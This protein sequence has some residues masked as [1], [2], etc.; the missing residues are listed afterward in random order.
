MTEDNSGDNLHK[1]LFVNLIVMLSSS[2]MQQLG[3]L[4]NPVTKEVEI[5]L[6]GAQAT[7]DMLE[8]IKGKTCG[9]LDEDEQRMLDEILSSLQMNYVQT[10]RAA[11]AS[12]TD[13]GGDTGGEPDSSAEATEEEVQSADGS[14]ESGDEKKDPKYHKSYGS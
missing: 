9:N 5:D 8:M 1:A 10:S 6:E 3:K 14:K 4:V 13:R 11:P 7:I 12:E 2:A